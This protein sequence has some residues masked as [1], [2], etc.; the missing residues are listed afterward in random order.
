ML[1][2]KSKVYR[3]VIVQHM[4]GEVV[5]CVVCHCDGRPAL[6]TNRRARW[7]MARV[8]CCVGDD[9]TLPY[10]PSL[11]PPLQLARNRTVLPG[12][13]NRYVHVLSIDV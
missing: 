5:R 12:T 4:R 11:R 8:S 6:D 1:S 10:P 2:V 7:Q 3:I 9:L 13:T